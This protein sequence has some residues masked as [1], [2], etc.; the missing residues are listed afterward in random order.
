MAGDLFDVHQALFRSAFEAGLE[1]AAYVATGTPPQQERWERAFSASRL[2]A[3]QKETLSRWTRT[4]NV[5]VLSGTWCGDCVRQVP[6]IARIA[7]ACPQINL[8]L[9]DNQ[10][11]PEV[12]NELR[13]H[14]ASRV[15][16]AVILSEDFFEVSRFGDRTLSHYRSKAARE[17]GVACDA[18]LVGPAEAELA[19]ELSEWLDVFE[20]GQLLLRTSGLL[21]SRYND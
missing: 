4:M 19:L 6:L 7:E 10:Q 11:H 9:I 13:V 17:T 8:R 1:Y 2:T 18:G 3:S 16:V 14:G 20:R 5:L 15:P 21:R 12:A